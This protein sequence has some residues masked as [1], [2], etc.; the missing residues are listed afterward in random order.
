MQLVLLPALVQRG[1]S[2][3]TH[4]HPCLSVQMM[5][6]HQVYILTYNHLV[7]VQGLRRRR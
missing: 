5:N 2:A 1:A 4:A 3:A 7:L 6:L